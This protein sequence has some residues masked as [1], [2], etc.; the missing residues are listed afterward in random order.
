V[1]RLKTKA[2][3]PNVSDASQ[4]RAMELLGKTTGLFDEG[5]KIVVEHRSEEEI[6]KEINERLEMFFGAEA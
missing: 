1:D 4:I 6:E 3:D 2:E 5:T